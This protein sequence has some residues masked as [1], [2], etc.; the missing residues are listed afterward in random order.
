MASPAELATM[1]LCERAE[2]DYAVIN[3]ITELKDILLAMAN[4][5]PRCTQLVVD[6]KVEEQE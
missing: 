2:C 5:L 3:G 6:Q 1:R 4:T